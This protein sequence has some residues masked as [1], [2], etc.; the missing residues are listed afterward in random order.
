MQLE[1][2]KSSQNPPEKHSQIS[3]TCKSIIYELKWFS[4]PLT[5]TCSRSWKRSS[6]FAV[7]DRSLGRHFFGVTSS[8]IVRFVSLSERA[9]MDVHVLILAV[10]LLSAIAHTIYMY[11]AFD[12]MY[13]C[14]QKSERLTLQ[15]LSVKVDVTF[16]TVA[17]VWH[18]LSQ[19]Q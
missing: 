17:L 14:N 3:L 19:M 18:H 6:W 4:H 2:R 13:A 7:L 12:M 9:T 10:L 5:L 11:E 15:S 8:S 1:S 16:R